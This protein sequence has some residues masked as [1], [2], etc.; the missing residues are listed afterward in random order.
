MTEQNE[1]NDR[2]YV[3]QPRAGDLWAIVVIGGFI[4]VTASSAVSGYMNSS[5]R[6]LFDVLLSIL[7]LG[8]MSFFL[9]PWIIAYRRIWR[10]RLRLVLSETTMTASRHGL[11][12]RDVTISYDSIRQIDLGDHPKSQREWSLLVKHNRGRLRI[13]VGAFPRENDIHDVA[14]WLSEKTG[15]SVEPVRLWPQFSLRTL[16]M[17]TTAVA[18][19]L[20]AAKWMEIPD[21]IIAFF[22]CAI[23][24]YG[25][26]LT[27]LFTS[28][29]LLRGYNRRRRSRL[30]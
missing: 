15:L 23:L 27:L 5:R 16:F 26:F 9:G 19:L 20:G 21:D 25:A 7:P 12:V 18:L 3:Y 29:A 1:S 28:V 4:L 11:K 22:T 8:I 10:G 17:I 24:G 30:K 13:P 14:Q 6:D 2:V